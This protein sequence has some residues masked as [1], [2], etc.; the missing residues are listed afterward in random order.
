MFNLPF[1]LNLIKSKVSD[2]FLTVDIG[3]NSIKCLAFELCSN[4]DHYAKVIGVSKVDLNPGTIREGNIVDLKAVID[5]LDTALE[6]ITNNGSEPITDVIFGVGGGLAISATTT[7]RVTRQSN[8]PITQEEFDKLYDKIIQTAQTQAYTKYY[9]MRG[10]SEADL[11]MTTASVFYLKADGKL[12]NEVIGHTV[13]VLDVAM[14]ASFT[15]SYHIKN[16][17]KIG[18]ELDLKI[19]AIG[20]NMYA[21]TKV[22]KTTGSDMFDCVFIDINSDITDIGVIFGG[23]VICTNFINLGSTHF[24]QE[25]EFNMGL[26][27]KE[28]ERVKAG[29]CQG[30]LTKG[31]EII[32]QNALQDI[33]DIWLDSIELIFMEFSGVKTFASK[34]YLTGEGSELEDLYTAIQEEPWT[35]SIP[36]RSPPEFTK[37]TPDKIPC[38]ID[39]TGQANTAEYTIPISLAA[40]QLELLGI[41]MHSKIKK[42]ETNSLI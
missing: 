39:F 17:Q 12:T 31:E 40:I 5:A 26:T 37:L 7:V 25:I 6:N 8:T 32:I 35:K 9:E 20:S 15:P 33:T 38:I 4:S 21:L 30:K 41:D 10:D 27:Q 19:N 22:I 13:K 23:G 28:A 16:L 1:N 42:L 11:E 3:A 29:Y 24:T 18:K 2:K 14:F 36:F 34:I